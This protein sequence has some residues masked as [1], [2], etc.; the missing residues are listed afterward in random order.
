[1]ETDDDF[2][3]QERQS[4]DEN[5]DSDSESV[6]VEASE[7]DAQTASEPESEPEPIVVRT[8]RA[9]PPSQRRRG[10]RGILEDI[11]EAPMEVI[12]EVCRRFTP[13]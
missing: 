4:E 3:V 11:K 9:N 7:F 5:R 2:E 13:S 8:K 6:D 1:M 10:M 12:Y